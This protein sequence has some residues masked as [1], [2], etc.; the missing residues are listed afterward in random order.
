MKPHL[1]FPCNC[2]DCGMSIE[3]PVHSLI[4]ILSECKKRSQRLGTPEALDAHAKDKAEIEADYEEI[5]D[6]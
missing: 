2:F 1:Y 5:D 3:T 4:H 6:D